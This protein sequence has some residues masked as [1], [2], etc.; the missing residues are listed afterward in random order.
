[1]SDPALTDS[2]LNKWKAQRTFIRFVDGNTKNCAV[3]NLHYVLLPDALDH[4]D[5][6]KVDWDMELTEEEIALVKKPE[7]RAGWNFGGQ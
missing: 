2:I 3:S 7:W 5:N 6:W 1:M 4:I